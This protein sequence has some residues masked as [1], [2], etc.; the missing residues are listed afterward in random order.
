ML[1]AWFGSE[2]A[3]PETLP[4][5]A[6]DSRLVEVRRRL[7]EARALEE[8]AA[9]RVAR[10]TR[11]VRPSLGGTA[12]AAVSER[13]YLEARAQLGDAERAWADARLAALA[14]A[15]EHAAVLAVVRREVAAAWRQLVREQAAAF[16][17]ALE[18]LQA[19]EHTALAATVEAA[20]AAVEDQTFAS[21][22][23]WPELL[24]TDPPS[25]ETLAAFR[26]RQL[27]RDGWLDGEGA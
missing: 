22:V 21:G 17:A 6:G 11:I 26:R 10:L 25:G 12:S 1:A 3:A 9:A 7:A 16:W 27:V 13:E 23:P 19:D 2:Q 18:R 20:R 24:L 5:V 15:D 4:T 14:L 8:D